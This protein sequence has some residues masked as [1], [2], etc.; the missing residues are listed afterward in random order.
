MTKDAVKRQGSAAAAAFR[1]AGGGASRWAFLL[2]DA[3]EY[4]AEAVLAAALLNPLDPREALRDMWRTATRYSTI[5]HPGSFLH[6][7][8]SNPM[9]ALRWLVEYRDHFA[10][11]GLW[12]LEERAP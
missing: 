7:L 10:T 1:E 3:R 9:V 12:R 11:F 5:L 2:Y 6:L 4:L 8:D